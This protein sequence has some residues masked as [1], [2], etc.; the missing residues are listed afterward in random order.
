M[1]LLAFL[2][3]GNREKETK[4]SRRI[5]LVANIRILI[6]YR[7]DKLKIFCETLLYRQ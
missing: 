3:K 1:I 2:H 6:H 5:Y 7:D 4:G